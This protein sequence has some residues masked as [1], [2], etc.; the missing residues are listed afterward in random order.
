MLGPD[1]VHI[2]SYYPDTN[3]PQPVVPGTS[4]AG[5]LRARVTRI[6]HLLG[7]DAEGFVFDLFGPDMD[8][9][10]Q[11]RGSTIR[12]AE[13][14]ITSGVESGRVQNRVA[15][16][17]FTGGAR[18]T[19]LFNEQPLFG[20]G[21]PCIRI[22]ATVIHTG[23]DRRFNAQVGMLL[24]L[25][26]DLW[27]GELPLGGEVSVGRGRLTG[28]RASMRLEQQGETTKYEIVQGE[29]GLIVTDSAEKPLEAYVTALHTY[30]SAQEKLA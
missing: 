28:H 16:D 4:V 6:A 22:K 8:M 12:I 3:K 2:H 14:Y 17:R 20:R 11:P 25:L 26:K 29:D 23:D 1:M 13:S 19:A 27:L 5:A 24:L 18:D 10:K 30:L 21:E 15:I 9:V 7:A